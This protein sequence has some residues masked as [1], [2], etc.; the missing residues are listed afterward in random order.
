MFISL[1]IGVS[2]QVSNEVIVIACFFVLAL[3]SSLTPLGV[4]CGMM[5]VGFY[6]MCRSQ[7]VTLNAEQNN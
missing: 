2:E 3:S 4:L 6:E 5:L 1:V 7:Y